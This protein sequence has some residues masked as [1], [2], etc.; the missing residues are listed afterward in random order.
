MQ[1]IFCLN[2]STTFEQV[3]VQQ[4]NE[5][6]NGEDQREKEERRRRGRGGRGRKPRRETR[7]RTQS[8]EG[9]ISGPSPTVDVIESVEY[10]VPRISLDI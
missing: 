4:K 6:E 7:R 5:G 8:K 10:G 2:I 1:R 3:I 9:L